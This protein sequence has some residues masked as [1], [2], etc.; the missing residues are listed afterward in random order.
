MKQ[1]VLVIFSVFRVLFLDAQTITY[2]PLHGSYTQYVYRSQSWSGGQP[3]DN[4]YKTIWS[5]DTTIGGENYVRIFQYGLYYGGI[6]EDVPNQ[7]RYFIDKNNVEKNITID[8]FLS[9]GAVLSDSAVFLNAFRV[10][11]DLGPGDY[12]LFDTLVVDLVDSTLEANG[13][14]STNYHLRKLPYPVSFIYNSYRGLQSYQVF[15]FNT[16][17]LCYREDGEQTPPGQ[18]TPWTFMCDLGMNINDWSQLE[19]FPNPSFEEINLLGDL[20]MITDLTIYDTQGV[21]VK[22]VPLSD[23]NSRI[24]LKELKSGI[25]LLSFNGN[26][27][28]LRFQKM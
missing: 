7:Q 19:L 2:Q 13:T 23:V 1:I 12:D 15:E 17:Q 25:Y 16:D 9:V 26:K 5:G 22:Q 18:Q 4:Y 6:R 10:Y 27:K 24:S 11:N 3:A 21:L 20:S 14:Y 28:I 8:P